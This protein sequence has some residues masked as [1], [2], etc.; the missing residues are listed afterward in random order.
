[1]K[2]FKKQKNDEEEKD[3]KPLCVDDF[4]KPKGEP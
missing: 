1:M 2:R 4:I 3:V